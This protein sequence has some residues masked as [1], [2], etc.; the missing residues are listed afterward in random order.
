VGLTNAQRLIYAGAAE[1]IVA[2]FRGEANSRAVMLVSHYDSVPGAPGAADAGAGVAGILEALRASQAGG[3]L[4]N[5]L[6]VL[7]TDG[8]EAGLRARQH[9]FKIT[10]NSWSRWEC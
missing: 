8:E 10:R 5:D 1:N 4:R 6:I 2:A 7:F 3:S 9:L